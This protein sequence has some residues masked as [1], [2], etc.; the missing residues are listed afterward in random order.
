MGDWVTTDPPAGMALHSF[1]GLQP[2][3]AETRDVV[4]RPKAIY[5]LDLDTTHSHRLAD[6]DSGR[7]APFAAAHRSFAHRIRVD[8]PAAAALDLFTPQG[9]RRWIAEWDPTFL[10]PADGE[11]QPGLVLTTGAGPELTFWSVDDFDRA[12]GRARYVRVTPASR[13]VIIEVLVE[14]IAETCED[15]VG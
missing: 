9:E 12:A 1:D 13:S 3:S 6:V 7:P 8:Q 14:P 5:D 10:H 4:A 11:T 2:F 15:E